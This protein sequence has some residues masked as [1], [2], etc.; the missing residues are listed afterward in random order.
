MPP[1]PEAGAFKADQKPVASQPVASQPL[2]TAEQAKVPGRPE[3][4]ATQTDKGNSS[5]KA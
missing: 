5:P 4:N 1:R 3:A 2:K